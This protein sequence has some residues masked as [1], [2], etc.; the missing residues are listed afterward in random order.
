VPELVLHN[1]QVRP[2]GQGEGGGT[3][4]QPVQRDRRQ[5]GPGD[6]LPGVSRRVVII[7]F[8]IMPGVRS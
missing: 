3:V 7:I 1:L 8:V 4:P 2:G 5:P 6:Q